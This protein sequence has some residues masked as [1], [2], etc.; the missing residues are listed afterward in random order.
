MKKLK[1][2]DKLQALMTEYQEEAKKKIDTIKKEYQ[3]KLLEEKIKLISQIAEGE[4]IDEFELK[5]KYLKTKKQKQEKKVV[6]SDSN[7]DILSHIIM[8]G[9]EYFY[10]DKSNGNVYNNNSER[11]GLYKQGCIKLDI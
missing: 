7:T 6:T 10:E 2:L 11:V 9:E 3:K 8:D 1:S 5:E 4:E